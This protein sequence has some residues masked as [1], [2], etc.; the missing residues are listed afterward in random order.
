MLLAQDQYIHSSYKQ[1]YG[2]R[3]FLKHNVKRVV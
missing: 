3:G 1:S 2:V